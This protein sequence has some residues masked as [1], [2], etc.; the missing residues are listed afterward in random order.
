LRSFITDDGTT[1]RVVE[2][3]IAVKDGQ[4]TTVKFKR[5]FLAP[6]TV[7]IVDI[8]QSWARETPFKRADFRIVAVDEKSFRIENTHPEAFWGCWA[9]VKWRAEGIPDPTKKADDAGNKS[10]SPAAD[11]TKNSLAKQPS[12]GS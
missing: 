9:S 4:E 8:L 2:G 6:P 12:S 7:Q 1:A 10:A 5:P 11:P 3:Q